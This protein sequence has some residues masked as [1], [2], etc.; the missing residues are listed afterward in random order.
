MLRKKKA[1]TR[2]AVLVYND[3]IIAEAENSI[4]TDMDFT[5]HAELNLVVEASK[6]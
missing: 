6:S 2:G 4:H 3:E 1:H 5:R